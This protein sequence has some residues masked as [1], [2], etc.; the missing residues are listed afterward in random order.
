L[1]LHPVDAPGAES[2]EDEYR[3]VTTG[4]FRTLGISLKSGRFFLSSDVAGSTPVA[5]INEAMAR[6]WWPNTTAIGHYIRV[7]ERL[8]PQP[9]DNVRQIVGIVSDTHEK[10]PGHPAVPTVFVPF[11]Q[12]PDNITAFFNKAFLT[13]IIVRTSRPIDLSSKI[14]GA[15]QA[16]NP[17][18]PLA[19]FRPFSDVV[20][21]SLARPRFLALLT[22][23]FGS[24]ALLLTAVGMQ[25]L[26]AYQADLRTREMAIRMA[27]GASRLEIIGMIVQQG[28]RMVCLAVFVGVG[29]AFV[30]KRLLG[31]L[32]YNLQSSSLA[33]IV[34]TGFLLASVATLISLLT[35]IRAA[36]IEPV[37]VLRNE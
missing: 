33:V 15:I 18:L 35:A 32:L 24:L 36:Y 11:S 25:G 16:V 14:R 6:R 34:A 17:E 2:H 37:A 19:S 3:P 7:D 23:A 27:V 28:A 26:L 5:I 1:P 12:T 9:P 30:I 20:N 31:S 22:A 13:S 29:G 4:Y 10:G 21:Q 8:G